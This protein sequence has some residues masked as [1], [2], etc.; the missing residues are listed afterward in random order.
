MLWRNEFYWKGNIYMARI[1]DIS[2]ALHPGMRGVAIDQFTSIEDVGWNTTTLKLYSHAGTHVD[3]PRHFFNQGE[4]LES[5]AIEK[6]IGPARLI[7]LTFLKFRSLITIE[8]LRPYSD[9]ISQ[10]SRVLFKTGWSAYVD[11]PNYRTHFPRI[12][13]TLA[14]W[15]SERQIAL[16][17]V[18]PPSVADINNKEEL[19]SV[20]QTL[21]AAG[22]V[23]IEGLA[24]LD[25]IYTDSVFLIALPLKI[26]GG[27]GSPVR[28][29][30]IEG[31]FP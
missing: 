18:E 3:A 2:H 15:L 30:A 24:H 11:Q 27:D 17:G 28:A 8:H 1:V 5:L 22:I 23:I 7:D 31:E 26:V 4:S 10:G 16:I 12:S 21:L 14:Q 20:H 25:Q 19:I 13:L 6:C 9:K 29:I